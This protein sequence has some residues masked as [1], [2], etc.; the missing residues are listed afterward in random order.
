MNK[1]TTLRIAL[2][3]PALL[4]GIIDGPT[5]L[6]WRSLLFAMMGEPLTDEER[7]VFKMLTLRDREPLMQVEEFTAVIGRRGGKSRAIA[8]LAAY[9]STLV[10]YRNVLSPG[11]R[12][13][14]LIIAPNRLQAGV[15]FDYCCAAI[16]NSPSLRTLIDNKTAETLTLTNNISIEVRSSRFRTLRGPTYIAALI[17]EIAFLMTDEFGSSNP[18]T[19]IV[20]SIRPGLATTGGPLLLASSP[21]ARRGVLWDNYRRN[22]G[23]SGDPLALVAQAP[24]V[25]MNPSLPQRIIDREYEKDAAS[26]AAEYGAQF[27]TDIE[28]FISREAVEACVVPGRLELPYVA[29]NLYRA[30]V[31]PSGG[32][33]DSFCLAIAHKDKSK[34][35]ILDVAR[36]VRPPFAPSEVVASFAELLK[37]YKINR[38]LGDRYA[39]E[40]PVEAFKRHHITYEQSAKPKSDLYQAMVPML[41]SKQ[42]E[43]LDIPKIT[44]QFS[45]LERRTSRTGKDTIDHAPGGHDD[46][47][48]AISGALTMLTKKGDPSL[49]Q[50]AKMEFGLGLFQGGR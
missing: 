31:D 35:N 15:I 5:W 40:W 49:D 6:A 38:I 21:Y 37:A 32:S 48:N 45:A 7:D 8:T 28:S 22:F 16:E 41:S 42:C 47:V 4:G 23:A 9:L 50:W 11:E 1:Q 18:D 25:A 17:D 12:G 30:F 27:R 43:L 14:C 20:K 13:V 46:F 34:I 10:D 19:E 26:A 2:N 29:G 39:G 24:T 36:E 44:N 3:E 33:S